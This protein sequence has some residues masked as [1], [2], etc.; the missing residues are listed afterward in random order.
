LG[1]A[2]GA[3]SLVGAQYPL[4]KAAQIAGKAAGGC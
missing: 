1:T 4:A 2:T 3:R